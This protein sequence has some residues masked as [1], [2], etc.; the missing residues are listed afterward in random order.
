MRLAP[1]IAV[2]NPSDKRARRAAQLRAVAFK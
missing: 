1:P 2:S